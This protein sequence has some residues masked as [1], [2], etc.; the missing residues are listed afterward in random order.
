MVASPCGQLSD[1]RPQDPLHKAIGRSKKT[2]HEELVGAC[3]AGLTKIVSRNRRLPFAYRIGMADGFV[4]P[5]GNLM[6]GFSFNKPCLARMVAII[7]TVQALALGVDSPSRV[8]LS[9]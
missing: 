4:T 7:A 5:A 2:L 6:A 9:R 1:P 3:D 8:M